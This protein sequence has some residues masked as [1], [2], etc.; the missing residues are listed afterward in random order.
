MA[1]ERGFRVEVRSLAVP[2]EELWSRIEARNAAS[3]PCTFRVERA[4]LDL[5]WSDYEPPA[6]DEL[7]PQAQHSHERGAARLRRVA[8]SPPTVFLTGGGPGSGED[9]PG[10]ATGI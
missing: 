1:R 3:P 7:Q 5:W 10:K 2:L 9:H 4:D 8:A 6:P